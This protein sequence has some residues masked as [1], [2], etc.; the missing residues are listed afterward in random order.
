MTLEKRRRYRTGSRAVTTNFKTSLVSRAHGRR[1]FRGDSRLL[2]RALR[3]VFFT[4]WYIIESWSRVRTVKSVS[5]RFS[6]VSRGKLCLR[7][8]LP[9]HAILADRD[10]H[11][12]GPTPE[13]IEI[14]SLN[15]QL[16]KR[17]KR[18]HRSELMAREV[19]LESTV[20]EQVLFNIS[21]FRHDR[22]IRSQLPFMLLRKYS[23]PKTTHRRGLG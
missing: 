22:S 20:F 18:V 15:K 8:A 12:P 3:A 6:F 5:W 4:R 10:V 23:W 1:G 17:W 16:L 2:L 7:I 14:D 21:L 9:D 19:Y 13:S 11:S